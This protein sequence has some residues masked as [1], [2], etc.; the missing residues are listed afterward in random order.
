MGPFLP[1]SLSYLVG[2]AANVFVAGCS[3]PDGDQ[4]YHTLGLAR[5]YRIDQPCTHVRWGQR[6]GEAGTVG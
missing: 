5:D 3:L 4:T 1:P 2:V 6:C